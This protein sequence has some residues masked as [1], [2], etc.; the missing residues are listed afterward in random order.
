MSRFVLL[1]HDHPELHWDLMLECGAVLRT[2]RL[3]APPCGGEVITA[4]ASFDH[5]ALYL[6]YEGPISG[7]RGRVIRWDR[8]T[9]IWETQA[10]DRVV[11]RLRGERL[12]G[13]LRLEQAESDDWVGGFLV[14][15]SELGTG[16]SE[17]S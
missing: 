3:T 4:M 6:D 17:E 8:G 5:R 1:E 13:I 15:A 12:R 11:V 16:T 14:D 10:A 7:D 2:W 9:F